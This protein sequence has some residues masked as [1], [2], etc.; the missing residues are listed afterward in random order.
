MTNEYIHQCSRLVEYRWR[1]I[2][3]DPN[4][5]LN[6]DISAW[7]QANPEV[8]QPCAIDETNH[9]IL[10]FVTG[11]ELILPMA[12]TDIPAGFILLFD[13]RSS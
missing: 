5:S 8:P 1:V 12:P 6:D 2:E 9:R 4:G 3:F 11:T 7:Q 10:I 13:P